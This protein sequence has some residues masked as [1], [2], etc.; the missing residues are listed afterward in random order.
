MGIISYAQNF[1]DVLL[2]R[3]F[4]GVNYGFYVDIGAYHPVDDNVTK[5][6]Y[7]RGWS[8]INIEPGEVFPELAAARTRDINLN[9]AVYDR[10]GE[11]S[12][13][14]H[15]GWYAGL[16]HV[17]DGENADAMVPASQPEVTLRTVACDTLTNILTAHASRRPIAFL[18]I[19]AEG[20]E[21]AIIRSTDWRVIRPTV[22]LIEA[23]MPLSNE[24]DN[25]DWEPILIEQ[26]YVRACFDGINCFYVPEE[27]RDLLR[28]FE[29][30]VNVLDG[31][32]RYDAAAARCREELQA[33]QGRIHTL[34][35]ELAR[36][37]AENAEHTEQ[38]SMFLGLM[39]THTET[40][41]EM[42][43]RLAAAETAALAQHR[44]VHELRWP[45]GPGAVRAVLPLARIIRALAG[46][47]ASPPPTVAAPGVAATA[48]TVPAGVAV[49]PPHVDIPPGAAAVAPPLGARRRSLAKRVVLGVYGV[50]RP[51]L[52]PLA[53]R[54]RSFL[55]GEL[56]SDVARL[57]LR[58]QQLGGIGQV[59][60]VAGNLSMVEA[61]LKQFGKMLETTL[62][63]LALDQERPKPSE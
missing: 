8:G 50:F 41:A 12:F 7:D 42:G 30:P 9:M 55:T 53:W 14:Q 2:N 38:K 10:A 51:V 35:S 44:L 18:K 22:L 57:E 45:D 11:I 60:G 58:I 4:G 37:N 23:T 62:V 17:Q 59:P 31:F 25:Q 46:R 21:L 1:E 29:L 56:R 26:G 47:R 63:T 33:A 39:R 24:L 61:E 54:S 40:M 6:F 3:V 28:H 36:V 43:Q 5:A 32:S 49:A 13:A 15:P 16:S 20:A 48:A 27:R 52:R 34:S 19:D